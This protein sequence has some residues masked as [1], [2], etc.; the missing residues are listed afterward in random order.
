[1]IK[2]L[3][4]SNYALIREL[5]LTP[6][7][8]FNII[9]GETGAGKSI[10][11]GALA[12]LQGKR[13]DA[14]GYVQEERSVVEA[15]FEVSTST[16][17]AINAVLHEAGVSPVESTFT[18]RREIRPTG[19][20]KAWVNG[21]QVQLAVLGDVTA[22]I[23]DIH[24]QHKN[25]LLADESFQRE[26]LDYLA[27]NG[28]LLEQYRDLYA[29]YR[30]ALQEFAVTREEISRTSADADYL[31][32]QLNELEALDLAPGEEEELEQQRTTLA[33]ASEISESLATAA[34]ALSWGETN[35]CDML[36]GAISAMNDAAEMSEE[37]APLAQRLEDIRVELDDV[38]DSISASATLMRDDPASLDNI[39]KRLSRIYTLKNKHRVDSVERL[40]EI[41]DDL[42]SRLS[43]LNDSEHTLKQLENAARKLKRQSL[44][45]ATQLSSRR[46][47]AASA[48]VQM[49]TE[50]ARPL[51]MA[52]LRFDV[53]VNTGKLNPNGVDSVE[54]LFSF[55]KN[56]EPAPVG[57]R[58]SGG[59]ISRLMLALKSVTAEHQNLPTI[60]FD[61]IDTGVSG[62][63]ARRMGLLMAEIGSHMQVLT[64][65][66]LP[67]V[68]ALG[69][70][71][72]KVYKTDDDRST[73]THIS[74]LDHD[75]R[76]SELALMLSGNPADEAALAAADKMLEHNS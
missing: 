22:K 54:Y 76:R 31:E 66:H 52:N 28:A 24:S 20:S 36:S 63:V 65:T 59:E 61:E 29:R 41:R 1:M 34:Q 25:L 11:M 75:M 42:A 53:R 43:A 73:Q 64:I 71:H 19:R 15:D 47:S 51:G 4:I 39:E 12:L 3:R 60:I 58:A 13:A 72:F 55:N 40:I 57:A 45:V 70:R 16:A 33:N 49:L 69:L 6:H 23:V 38:S 21:T 67:Q 32:F 17:S 56:Q 68:A 10:I 5:E 74:T 46:K 26:V 48:L 35:A 37:F 9:T 14:R 18:L 62:E 7:P 44:E 8:G 30:I 50:R 27:D 2:R